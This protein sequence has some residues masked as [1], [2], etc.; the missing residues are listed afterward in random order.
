MVCMTVLNTLH[1]LDSTEP[2][3]FYIFLMKDIIRISTYP[4][5]VLMKLYLLCVRSQSIYYVEKFATDVSS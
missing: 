4:M 1:Q 5:W 2:V 3:D